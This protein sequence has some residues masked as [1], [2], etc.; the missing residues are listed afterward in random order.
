[1]IGGEIIGSHLLIYP[2]PASET[3]NV[4]FSNSNNE[5][6]IFEISNY[7]GLKILS[8][9]VSQ[10]TKTVKLDISEFFPGIYFFK[11]IKSDMILMKPFIVN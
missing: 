6:R 9:Q 8:Q 4:E 1:M 2:N 10:N 11:L 5:S 7:L 3:L